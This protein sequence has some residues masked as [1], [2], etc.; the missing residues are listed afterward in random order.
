MKPDWTT[1]EVDT[2]HYFFNAE[3]LDEKKQQQ[4]NCKAPVM[5]RT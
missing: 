1:R 5:E 3:T 2:T 4:Q